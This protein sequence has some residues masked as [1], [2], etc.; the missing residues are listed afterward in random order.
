MVRNGIDQRSRQRALWVH[1]NPASSLEGRETDQLGLRTSR[2][3]KRG[4]ARAREKEGF[5]HL[6]REAQ[7]PG[8]LG[9][10]Q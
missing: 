7:N 1:S 8:L 3:R 10:R 9:L 4:R 2:T 5:M 6:P